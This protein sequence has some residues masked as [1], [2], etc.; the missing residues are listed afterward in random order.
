MKQSI[1]LLKNK[2]L[3]QPIA[4]LGAGEDLQ[5]DVAQLP[6]NCIKIVAND[7]PL[8]FYPNPEYVFV[9]SK[10][11]GEKVVKTVDPSKT[12]VI[13]TFD[14]YSDYTTN[15]QDIWYGACGAGALATSLA[16]HFGGNPIALCGFDLF[17][18][19]HCDGIERDNVEKKI[20]LKTLINHW[21]QILNFHSNAKNIRV[22]GG[23]PLVEIFPKI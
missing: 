5:K 8:K 18:K 14:K 20:E 16:C 1:S 23:S 12:I 10:A 4:V 21:K 22:I 15:R 19:N 9:I 13:S 17:R 3:N 11:L 2:H 7:K 6:E